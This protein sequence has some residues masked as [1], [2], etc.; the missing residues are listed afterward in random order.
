MTYKVNRSKVTEI[1]SQVV[2]HLQLRLTYEMEF[3]N[4][5]PRMLAEKGKIYANVKELVVTTQRKKLF[6]MV[7]PPTVFTCPFHHAKLQILLKNYL[8][9]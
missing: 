9:G 7:S 1:T 3:V 4:T 2:D 6:H 5:S 8:N